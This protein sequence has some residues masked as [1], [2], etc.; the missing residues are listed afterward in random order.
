MKSNIIP[1]QNG[2]VKSGEFSYVRK[3]R[4]LNAY[5]KTYEIPIKTVAFSDNLE[6]VRKEI[7]NT[8]STSESVTAIKKGIALF[9]GEDE[10]ERLFPEAKLQEIDVDEILGFWTA[11]NFEMNRNQNELLARY[12]AAKTIRG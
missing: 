5:G 12:S 10:T 2:V 8:S 4:T 3:P 7:S 11:L 9:I 1:M 6:D